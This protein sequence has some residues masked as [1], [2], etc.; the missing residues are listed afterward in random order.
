MA[1]DS[2]QRPRGI[3]VSRREQAAPWDVQLEAQASIHVV[4]RGSFHLAERALEAGDIALAGEGA[5]LRCVAGSDHGGPAE[6]ISAEYA[7]AHNDASVIHLRAEDVRRERGLAIVVSLLR[8]ALMDDSAGQEQLARSLLDPLLAYTLHCHARGNGKAK[9]P[10][11]PR[12]ARVLQML[13]AK[14]AEPWTVAA[15]AKAA[16]LS[17]AA[18]A[19]RFLADLGMPPLRYLAELRMERAARLLA[20][21]DASLAFIAAQIGYESEFAFSRAFKRHMGEAPG[22]YRRRR[23]AERATMR[24]SSIRAAA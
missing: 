14:L 5:R 7:L 16:G 1:D 18:F 15:L 13:R 10:A 21:G 17:R 8:A 22:V 24:A 6:L 9:E 23:H 4:V 3:G 11:D 2:D 12:I 20:E 19:R